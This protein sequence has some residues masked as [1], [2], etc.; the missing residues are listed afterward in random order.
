MTDKK[1]PVR[2]NG[3]KVGDGYIS[4]S[5]FVL[6]ITIEDAFTASDLDTWADS[7]SLIFDGEGEYTLEERQRVWNEIYEL[8]A[9]NEKAR[10]MLLENQARIAELKA[11]SVKA[12]AVTDEINSNTEN[13]EN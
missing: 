11:L 12:N 3:E 7:I 8:E 4:V 6:S 2:I 5:G 9:W 10:E 1:I 13:K